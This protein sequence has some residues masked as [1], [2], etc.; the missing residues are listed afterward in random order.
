MGRKRS[1]RRGSPSRALV[2]VSPSPA[3]GHNS[4]ADQTMGGGL[5]GANRS[6]REMASWRPHLGSP[7]S[8]ISLGKELADA[9]SNDM[10]M[11][12]G[13]AMG[14]VQVHKDSIVGSH[15]RLNSSPDWEILR[16]IH[17]PTNATQEQWIEWAELYQA[18]VERLFNLSAESDACWLD[19]SRRMTLT[20]MVRL[21]AG[22][23]VSTGEIVTTGEWIRESA[24]PFNTAV[25]VISP[26]R[27]SNPNNMPDDKRTRG[28]RMVRGIEIDFRGRHVAYHFQQAHPGDFGAPGQLTWK[29]VEAEKPW[30]R[31]QVIYINDPMAPEQ[32]RGIAAMVSALENMKMTKNF[33]KVTLQNAVVNASYAASIESELPSYDIIAAMGGGSDKNGLETYLKS[34]LDMLQD[35]MGGSNNIQLDGAMIPHF[36]PGTK[37]NTRPLGTP[38]GVG[39]DFEASLLRYTAAALGLSYS[40]FS[41]DYSKLSYSGIRGELGET[42]KFFKSRKKSTADKYATAIMCLWHEEQVGKGSIPLPPGWTRDDY[43]RPFAREALTKCKWIGTGRGQI[44]ELKET[45][46][47]ILR[48]KAGLSTREEEIAKLGNDF[49]EVLAQLEREEKLIE[50]HNLSGK[51]SLDAERSSSG[52]SSQGTLQEAEDDGNTGA[53]NQ[54][55]DQ[56]D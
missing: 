37:L 3:I 42:E 1:N 39:T 16:D 47:A 18:R 55:S 2:P 24:R 14:A 45:Q 29:R 43:Y 40:Q 26:A 49:R 25:Q 19:A 53:N 12:D 38:G 10:V 52:A 22:S 31:K 15:F 54:N 28:N 9:R 7:D 36:F 27:L 33:R 6:S 41:R 13:F 8:A 51:L 46:A 11:N 34:Y 32:T 21:G 5:E 44:D 35:Y 56:E 17:N 23:F 4:G 30:G 48:I 50:A 20:E